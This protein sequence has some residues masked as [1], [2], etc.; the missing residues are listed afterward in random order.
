MHRVIDISLAR[1]AEPFRLHEDAFDRL[2]T[3]LDQADAGLRHDADR[4]EVLGDLEQ[5]IGDRLTSRLGADRRVV[6]L[7][8]VGA[9]LDEVGA[10]EGEGSRGTTA[11]ALPPSE[12]KRRLYRIREGQAIAG[13]CTGIAAYADISVELVRWVVVGLTIVTAGVFGFVYI[14]LVLILRVMP[15]QEA[16]MA[17]QRAPSGGPG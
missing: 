15:T 11:A 1:H 14:A 12:G 6:D 5:A 4:A 7:A 9:V 8:D 2:R 10:V 3:Y 13:V 17:A 16:F